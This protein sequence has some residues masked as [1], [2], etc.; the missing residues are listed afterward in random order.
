MTVVGIT[1]RPNDLAGRLGGT[2]IY[3]DTSAITVGP[4]WWQA[5]D[6]DAAAYGIGVS[7]LTTSPSVS[8]DVVQAV[9]ERW[10]DRPWE[11]EVSEL[12][13]QDSQQTAA[14]TRSGSRPSGST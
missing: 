3:T 2:S 14:A 9:N 13:G 12:F 11:V 8:D 4:G 1:R 10:P 5:I 6:G 7:V